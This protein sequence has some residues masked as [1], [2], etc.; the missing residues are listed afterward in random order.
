MTQAVLRPFCEPLQALAA[1]VGPCDPVVP[2]G[3]RTQWEIGGLPDPGAREVFL[4]AGILEYEPAEMT[5][6]CLAGTTLAELAAV[7]AE[8]GQMVPLDLPHAEVATVGGVLAVGRSG[9]KRLG[10]GPIRDVL[11]Q[12]VF[13]TADGEL[14]RSGGPTVKNVSG[15][16]LCR[17]MVGS[18]GTLGVIGEVI[19]RCLPRPAVSQWFSGEADPFELLHRLYRPVSVLWDGTRVWLCLEGHSA[20]V[21]AQASLTSLEPCAGPPELPSPGRVSLRP[22]EL[23]SLK[24]EFVAEVGVG[25]AHLPD[26]TST[27]SLEARN[28]ALCQEIKQRFDPLG[29]LN[30]GRSVWAEL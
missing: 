30:P 19:L 22:S 7:L 3:G 17:L 2:A 27:G 13:V 26:P 1:E 24:G 21:D 15:F 8:A 14:V 12:V 28:L 18:L 9:I 29:R 10:Y 5:V 20:D 25:V 4:P 23:K 16:D 6:R 11:L